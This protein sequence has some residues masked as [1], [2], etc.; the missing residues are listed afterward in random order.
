M[1]KFRSNRLGI[2]IEIT[3]ETLF[4]SLEVKETRN[5][6]R[7]SCEGKKVATILPD[8]KIEIRDLVHITCYK[9]RIVAFGNAYVEVGGMSRVF[10]RNRVCVVACQG[11]EVRAGGRTKVRALDSSR[12]IATGRAEV[13]LEGKSIGYRNGSRAR[14]N[15]LD[16]R[17]AVFD[18]S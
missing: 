1:R 17:A 3:G 2:E 9:G 12:V 14:I 4:K 10:A 11:A 6:A 15:K 5:C 8:S 7:I 13:F 18:I 16:N